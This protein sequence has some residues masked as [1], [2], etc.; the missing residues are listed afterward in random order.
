M[1]SSLYAVLLVQTQRTRPGVPRQ[2]RSS[3]VAGNARLHWHQGAL[4]WLASGMATSGSR[5]RWISR[6]ASWQSAPPQV[7][8]TLHDSEVLSEQAGASPC[9]ICAFFAYTTVALSEGQEHIPFPYS[10]PEHGAT[11]S[12]IPGRQ[13]TCAEASCTQR[14]LYTSRWSLA[15]GMYSTN[16]QPMP[17]C[18]HNHWRKPASDPAQTDDHSCRDGGTAS[19]VRHTRSHCGPCAPFWPRAGTPCA[20]CC[21]YLLTTSA[22]IPG[23]QPASR[24]ETPGQVLCSDLLF[25]ILRRRKT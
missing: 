20:H 25:T 7:I 3:T 8:C 24:S 23:G 13:A 2:M 16:W 12:P 1:H 10:L 19:P 11:Y 17:M 6:Q 14:G 4:F 22:G 5:R 21:W 18:P 15:S 9:A